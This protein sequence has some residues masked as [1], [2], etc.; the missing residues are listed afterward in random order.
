VGGASGSWPEVWRSRKTKKEEGTS[1]SNHA[2]RVLGI[3]PFARPIEGG[4]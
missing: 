1:L 3:F 4:G 2:R